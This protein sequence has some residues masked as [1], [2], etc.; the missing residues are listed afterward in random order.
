MKAIYQ[1]VNGR[2]YQT[3]KQTIL[4]LDPT[5]DPIYLRCALLERYGEMAI[6]PAVLLDDW[7]KEIKN[8]TLYHW[9][10][11]YGF[12]FPRAELFGFEVNG[13]QTQ[14]FLRDLELTGKYP[15]YAYPSLET[16]LGDGRPLT[17]IFTPDNDLTNLER[18]KKPAECEP[19]L[20]QAKVSW[21]RGPLAAI[22]RIDTP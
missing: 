16:P 4:I 22:D 10:Q 21:W 20:S 7:G 1:P 19:P 6:L 2:L 18:G 17:A 12:Q 8:L 5:A 14:Y 9:I 13:R 11:E 15:C 3:A